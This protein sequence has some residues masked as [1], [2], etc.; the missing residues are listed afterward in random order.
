MFP[1]AM[2]AVIAGIA[3]HAEAK[4]TQ[5]EQVL[6]AW[7]DRVQRARGGSARR[8]RARAAVR[9]AV[10]LVRA[11]LA[12]NRE[13]PALTGDPKMDRA[14]L[15]SLCFIGEDMAKA[16]VDAIRAREDPQMSLDRYWDKLVQAIVKL[17]LD[18]P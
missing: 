15:A 18:E 3:R 1:G 2:L 9:R 7:T 14:L 16:A 11:E 10:A 4:G 17:D 12:N 13:A 6:T 8:K 5:A